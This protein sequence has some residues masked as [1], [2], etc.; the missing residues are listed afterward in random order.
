MTGQLKLKLKKLETKE[1]PQ[2]EKGETSA[3]DTVDESDATV[4]KDATD[5]VEESEAF[6]GAKGEEDS[7][8]WKIDKYAPKKVDQFATEKVAKG[9]ADTGTPKG[10]PFAD[11]K[12]ATKEADTGTA[13][14]SQYVP[15]K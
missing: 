11:A 8:A 15:T 12:G 6:R 10:D 7:G 5:T 9:K 14:V 2:L 4:T 13:T 1:K 3:T